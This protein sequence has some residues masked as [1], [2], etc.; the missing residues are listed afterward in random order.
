M[1][2]K[3]D[4]KSTRT[5]GKHILH[6]IQTSCK[7]HASL[8]HK[9]AI[10]IAKACNIYCKTC[11]KTSQIVQTMQEMAICYPFLTEKYTLAYFFV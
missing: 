4:G 6:I 7:Q 10:L 5:F 2:L 8:L 9:R 1:F 3:F 11:K